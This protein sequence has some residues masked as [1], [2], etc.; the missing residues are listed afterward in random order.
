MDIVPSDVYGWC[1]VYKDNICIGKVRWVEI[2]KNYEN[3]WCVKD[4]K[5]YTKIDE[6]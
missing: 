4:G 5:L 2:D 1:Y 6:V 3:I